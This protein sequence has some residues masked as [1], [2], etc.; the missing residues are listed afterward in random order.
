VKV[1]SINRQ[2]MVLVHL[3]K[4]GELTFKI[5]IAKRAGDTA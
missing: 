1:R 4:K 5:I 3:G 2:I